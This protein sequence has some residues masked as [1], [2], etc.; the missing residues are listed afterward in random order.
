MRKPK[1]PPSPSSNST[2]PA[3]AGSHTRF[4]F[5][6]AIRVDGEILPK[7]LQRMISI[8][9]HVFIDIQAL[10]CRFDNINGRVSHVSL[11]GSEFFHLLPHV[12]FLKASTDEPIFIDVEEVDPT[13]VGDCFLGRFSA[14]IVK[15]LAMPDAALLGNFFGSIVVAQLGPPKLDFNLIQ[16]L[17]FYCGMVLHWNNLFISALETHMI[18]EKAGKCIR[19]DGNDALVVYSAV[20][21]TREIAIREK[22]PVLM[23]G[24][25]GAKQIWRE[26]K[27]RGDAG[28]EARDVRW[29]S[30]CSC[31]HGLLLRSRQRLEAGDREADIEQCR[32]CNNQ[33]IHLESRTIFSPG[34]HLSKNFGGVDKDIQAMNRAH[35]IGQSNRVLVYRFVV[36]ASVEKC[37][38]LNG[39]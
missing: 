22:R 16:S 24:K 38:M 7:T 13:G 8:W 33:A 5:R 18:L 36:C 3:T 35:I 23:R 25:K 1:S 6:L 39:M 2:T 11:R 31:R 15:G 26:K 17:E 37:I 12:V 9:D 34:F 29:K 21:T 19:V 28:G 30:D 14:G 32:G 20:H 10:I 27:R 4:G